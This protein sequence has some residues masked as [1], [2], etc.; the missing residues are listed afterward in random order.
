[1]TAT[2]PLLTAPCPWTQRRIPCWIE[3]GVV[4]CLAGPVSKHVPLR[5]EGGLADPEAFAKTLRKLGWK[6]VEVEG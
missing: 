1:M 5:I 4:V 6:N 3:S 2:Q